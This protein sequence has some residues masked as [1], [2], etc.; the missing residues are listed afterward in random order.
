MQRRGCSEQFA[1]ALLDAGAPLGLEVWFGEPRASTATTAAVAQVL[2]M[3]D[4]G[5]Q[6]RAALTSRDATTTDA[7]CVDCRLDTFLVAR[8]L[9]AVAME[10]LQHRRHQSGIN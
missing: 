5:S 2:L 9:H 10:L 4:D 6:V 7:L 1:E 8:V 3:L